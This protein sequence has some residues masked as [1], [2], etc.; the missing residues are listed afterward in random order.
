VAVLGVTFKEN[1]A[2]IRNS[3]V[4]EL[5]KELMQYAIHVHIHDPHASPNEVSKEYKFSLTK[6]LE[7]DYDAIVVAVN[8]ASYN[9]YDAVYFKSIM[10]DRPILFDIKGMYKID[11]PE[12]TYW[13][14]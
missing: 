12:I 9:A 4:A 6:T 5:I 2:D 10:K 8:H 1:V 11:D 14:L 7:D 3:K 13:S